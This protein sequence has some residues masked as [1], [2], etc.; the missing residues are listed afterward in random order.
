MAVRVRVGSSAAGKQQTAFLRP[1]RRSLTLGTQK[2]RFV[3]FW[4]AAMFPD[5]K[6]S[7]ILPSPSSPFF[8]IIRSLSDEI[9]GIIS[10]ILHV[11]L[12]VSEQG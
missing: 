11:V 1:R 12:M 8:F 6:P 10:I 3:L 5:I 9:I 7:G 2:W 4:N